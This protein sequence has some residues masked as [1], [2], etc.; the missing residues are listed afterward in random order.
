MSSRFAAIAF[1]ALLCSC[2]EPQQQQVP[3]P[4]PGA[5]TQ[6]PAPAPTVPTTSAPAPAPA[7]AAGCTPAASRL[8]PSDTGASDPSFEQFRKELRAAVE[9]KNGPELLKHV[10]T[11]VRTNFGS[12]GGIDDF[13]N[14]WKIGSA[15]SRLW[16]TLSTVL[17]GGGSFK[18]A[19]LVKM[20]WAPYTFANWPEAIDPFEHVAALHAGVVVRAKASNDASQVA[21]VDWE[22][23]KVVSRN[24]RWMKVKTSGGVE[25]WVSVADVYSPIGY[26]AGFSKHTGEWKLEALVAGD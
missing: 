5:P 17:D 22:I 14:G 8:C 9:Q 19:G 16:S 4:K 2:G 6:A 21:T 10:A 15:D 11:D 12:G 3:A 1:V 24:E 20:F 18:D 26:R 7:P 23:L 25:G 13:A